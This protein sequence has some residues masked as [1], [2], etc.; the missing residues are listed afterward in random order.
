MKPRLRLE[1]SDWVDGRRG[2]LLPNKQTFSIQKM[3][4]EGPSFIL[5]RFAG[6]DK[7]INLPNWMHHGRYET[8]QAARIAAEEWAAEQFPLLVLAQAGKEL[9]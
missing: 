8:A 1:W 7:A 6:R 5:E 3:A 2:A 9:P 4:I